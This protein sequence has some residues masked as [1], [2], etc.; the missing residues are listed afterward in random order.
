MKIPDIREF[1]RLCFRTPEEVKRE[2]ALAHEQTR[3]CN[4]CADD[5]EDDVNAHHGHSRPRPQ[6]PGAVILQFRRDRRGVAGIEFAIVAPLLIALWF[7][8]VALTNGMIIGQKVTDTARTVT[9][10]VTQQPATTQ[11]ASIQAILGAG[12]AIVAPFS[13]TPLVVVVSEMLTSDS[14]MG[15][16]TVVWSQSMPTGMGR[17]VGEVIPLPASMARRPLPG[18]PA[19]DNQTKPVNLILGEVSYAY[20]P[21]LGPFQT[22]TMLTDQYWMYPRQA[23]AIACPDC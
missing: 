20:A 13:P 9:D 22:T 5:I 6:A 15:N 10:L 2:L 12:A 18:P 16:A 17:A 8:G 11:Q 21:N 3:L 1:K 19:T 4:A 7:G 23:T 14:D